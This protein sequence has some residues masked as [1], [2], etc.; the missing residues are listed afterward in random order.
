MQL[1]P[2]AASDHRVLDVLDPVENLRGGTAHLRMMLDRFQSLTLALAA[3]N[4]GATTVERFDGVPPYAETRQYVKKVLELF[5]PGSDGVP[6]GPVADW[7]SG[8]P[9][10]E[11]PPC[12]LLTRSDSSTGRLECQTVR[13][14]ATRP[15]AGLSR[16]SPG[17]EAG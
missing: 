16:R 8:R 15:H 4:A 2:S 5:C 14:M 3:Y 6:K 1:M 7:F 9:S 12:A 11:E 10:R 17:G 13:K